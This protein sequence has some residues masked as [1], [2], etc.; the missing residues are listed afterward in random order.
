MS[1][2]EKGMVHGRKNFGPA[3][4]RK[5]EEVKETARKSAQE[6]ANERIS[7]TRG[8][9]PHESDGGKDIKRELEAEHDG[10]YQRRA[11]RRAKGERG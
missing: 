9:P 2:K 3:P 11:Q 4:K 1:T 10:H 8:G 7:A 5:P 6:A